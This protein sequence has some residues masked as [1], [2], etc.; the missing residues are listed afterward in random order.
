MSLL[1]VSER[2]IQH[3]TRKRIFGMCKV[4]TSSVDAQALIEY[5]KDGPHTNS[6]K[7]YCNSCDLALLVFLFCFEIGRLKVDMS[8]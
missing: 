7:K 4:G 5:R 1:H 2:V 3:A 6:R 8:K